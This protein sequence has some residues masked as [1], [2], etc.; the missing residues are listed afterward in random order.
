MSIV[1]F[2]IRVKRKPD[3]SWNGK[4][5]EQKIGLVRMQILVQLFVVKITI[6][7]AYSKWEISGT[8]YQ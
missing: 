3:L 5:K 8:L 1:T 7:S 6:F 2:V 4:I